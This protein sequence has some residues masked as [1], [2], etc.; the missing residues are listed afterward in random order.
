MSYILFDTSWQKL[1]PFT[2]T[3]A[4]ADIL[5]GIMTM[6]E[7][8]HKCF[9]INESGTLTSNTAQLRYD[10]IS[11]EG[12]VTY[13]NAH[14]FVN[15][16]ISKAISNLKIGEKL[17]RNGV[18]IAAKGMHY[19]VLEDFLAA[20][21]NYVVVEYSSE[22]MYLEN[23][24]DIFSLNDA[25][26]RQDYNV[27]T[28]DRVSQNIPEGVT[29]VGSEIFIEEGAAIM[30]GTVINTNSGP[31]YLA[32]D[33][34]IW[35]GC[36]LR[37]PIAIG[38]HSVLKMS[39]KVYGATTI[40]AGSKVGGE[41]SNV[42]FFANSN[43]GHDGFLGNAVIGEWCNLG[44]DTNASNLK[45]NYDEVKIWDETKGELIKTGLTFCGLIMGDHSKCGI[46]T[47]FNT[48]TVVGV[49]CNIYG[50][51]FPDK[52]MPSF[53]WG[54]TSFVRYQFDKAMDTADRMM[55]RRKKKMTIG[56]RKMY[57]AIYDDSKKY[58][59]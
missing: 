40:G 35:E 43:K 37:G 4:V 41:V 13:L 53:S 34:E 31:V 27:L 9:G 12:D 57:E 2:H 56:E 8:W 51:D 17:E 49:S 28:K 58:F 18:V 10:E 36:M 50:G 42:V 46:N 48:G 52:F 23:V 59:V 16:D 24:W 19:S 38:E 29:V 25:A 45:N 21:S 54:G 22:V 44:A 32:K 15:T 39:A 55:A 30:P 33:A 11:I 1:L 3:R 7:R 6:R 14:V 26:I 47:M 20:L 5:C